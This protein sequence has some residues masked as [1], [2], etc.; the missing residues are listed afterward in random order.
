M[1]IS[2]GDLTVFFTRPLSL[3]LLLIAAA[4]A[5]GPMIW[6]LARKNPAS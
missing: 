6:R 1:T 4:G 2:Q 3:S 5:F